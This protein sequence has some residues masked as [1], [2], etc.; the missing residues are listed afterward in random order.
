[1]FIGPPTSFYFVFMSSLFTRCHTENLPEV[2]ERTSMSSHAGKQALSPRLQR[3]AVLPLSS[4]LMT[5]LHESGVETI[6]DLL[7]WRHEQRALSGTPGAAL[8]AIDH[9]LNSIGLFRAAPLP[10][11]NWDIYNRR[12]RGATFSSLA[13]KHSLSPAGARVA[14]YK[15]QE[16]LESE[17]K[18]RDVF[19]GQLAT[20]V[21]DLPLPTRA[22]FGLQRANV[23][24]LASL[25][26]TPPEAILQMRGLG[27]TSLQAIRDFQMQFVPQRGSQA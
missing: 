1:M 7:R 8:D 16:T 21:Q 18:V 10:P 14:F 24:T 5:S 9:A 15:V 12:R 19:G 11:R 3:V 6:E 4:H 20:K 27:A 13:R 25:L 23:F 2:I 17:L 22:K 26:L